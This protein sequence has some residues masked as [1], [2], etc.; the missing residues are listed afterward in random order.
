MSDGTGWQLPGPY[1]DAKVE[2][3]RELMKSA[4]FYVPTRMPEGFSN[5]KKIITL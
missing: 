5:S 3:C 4:E 1:I 2:L